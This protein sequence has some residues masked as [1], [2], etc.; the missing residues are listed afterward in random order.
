[1]KSG[2]N[3][4]MAAC[5]VAGMLGSVA[6][7]QTTVV[8]STTGGT[9]AAVAST[10]TAVSTVSDGTI[11][12]FSP[13]TIVVRST[14][15]AEPL[16]YTYRKTTTYVD[17]AGAPVSMEVVK[18]GVPVTVHYVRE[19]DEL[20]AS[21]VVVHRTVAPAPAVVEKRSTTT[22]TTTTNSKKKDDDDEDDD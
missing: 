6:L 15:A 20:V 18:S 19:G 17:E 2:F 8:Q 14:T 3:K 11:S 5:T 22:T 13:N 4:L 21:R 1:M 12:E 16:R 10:N 9:T 7:A